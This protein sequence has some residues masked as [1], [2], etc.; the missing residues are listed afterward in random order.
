MIEG[1]ADFLPE[2]KVPYISPISPPYLPCISPTSPLSRRLPAGREGPSGREALTLALA[3]N[4]NPN[5]N[6]KP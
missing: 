2:E 6:P 3:L 5:P 1:F 4:C